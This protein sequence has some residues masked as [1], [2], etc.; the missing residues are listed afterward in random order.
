LIAAAL[1]AG[2]GHHDGAGAKVPT[3]GATDPNLAYQATLEV[4]RQD[5]YSAA[6]DDAAPGTV[7][8][9]AHA[10]EDNPKGG[11]TIRLRV[12]FDGEVTLVPKGPLVKHGTARGELAKEIAKLQR[13]IGARLDALPRVGPQ[14]VGIA[15]PA[16]VVA[17]AAPAA[18]AP[19]APASPAAPAFVIPGATSPQGTTPVQPAPGPDWVPGSPQ[20]TAY[21]I[22]IGIEKYGAGVESIP[23]GRRDAERFAEMAKK[24]LGVPA[25]HIKLEV[26][27]QATKA[28]IESRL[29]WAQD[30]VPAGGRIYFY[31]SGHGV[32]DPKTDARGNPKGTAY[33]IPSDGD[34]TF[35]YETGIAVPDILQRLGRSKAREVLAFVDACYAGRDGERGWAKASYGAPTAQTALFAASSGA[36]TAGP[37]ASGDGGLFTSVLLEGVGRAAA[38]ENGDGQ[39]SLAEMNHWVSGQVSTKARQTHR[40]QDP[41]L[42]PGPGVAVDG[43]VVGWGMQKPAGSR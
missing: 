14:Q 26:N 27:E 22:V 30:N 36:Q 9:R 13:D 18:L 34:P 29:A 6:P 5:G 24:T 11:S 3:H 25:D 15:G 16:P 33:L 43:V 20:P 31:F 21:A 42:I 40:D 8:V 37:A 10:D 17:T 7:V 12:E 2:C 38:D 39:V 1:S 4:L 41:V 19:A 28:R 35:L 32:P 23:G